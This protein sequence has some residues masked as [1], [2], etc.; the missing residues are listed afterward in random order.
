MTRDPIND[1]VQQQFGGL[2]GRRIVAVEAL[3]R[4]QAIA[5]GFDDHML[6]ANPALALRLD[7]GST[8]LPTSDPEGN[9]PGWLEVLAQ[10]GGAA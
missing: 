10:K 7:D 9:A 8:I 2:V 4:Q 6:G 1:A 5:L 3:D